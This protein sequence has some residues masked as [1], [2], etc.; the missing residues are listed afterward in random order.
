MLVK[1]DA[2]ELL[3]Y[4]GTVYAHTGV[5]VDSMGTTKDWQWV[6]APWATNIQK[7]L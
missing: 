1:P 5:T 6:I 4:T 7:P 2:E 3:N